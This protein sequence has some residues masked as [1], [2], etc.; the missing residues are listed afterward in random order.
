AWQVFRGAVAGG[1]VKAQAANIFVLSD[2]KGVI[3]GVGPGGKVLWT[4]ETANRGA[5]L[6]SAVPFKDIVYYSGSN[7]FLAIDAARGKV[8][9]RVPLD[10]ARSHVLGNRVVPFPNAVVYPTMTSLDVLD[11]KTG[12]VVRSIPVPGGTTMTPA[13]YE[14]MAAIVNQKG[15]FMLIDL[16]SGEVSAQVQTGARQPVALA[17]RILGTKAAFADR[18]GLLVMVDL[19]TMSVA[20]ERPL[21]DSSGVFSDLEMGPEGVFAY[22][23]QTV[24]GYTLDGDQIM[25]PISG[26]TAPPLLTKGVLYYGTADGSLVA[27]RVQP[28]ELIGTVPLGGKIS[29]RP[30]F[31]DGFI[32]VGTGAGR[33]LKIDPAKIG[34]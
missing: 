10:G 25:E 15:V 5:E 13:N 2:P 12:Q 17:P 24:F 1:V 20:W 7:E 19:A 18:K 3:S 9:F 28:F 23:K 34:K 16:E 21:P 8:L 6:A 22:G 31:A 4:V 11:E 14:G 30:L 33:L 26:V 29:A 27:A 32:Y